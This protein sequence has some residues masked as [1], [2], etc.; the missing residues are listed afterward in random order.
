M[1]P[2]GDEHTGSPTLLRRRLAAELRRLRAA[3]GLGIDEVAEHLCC[4]TSKVSRLET[5]R[6]AAVQRDVRDL[7]DLY[8]V[9]GERREALLALARRARRREDWW[10]HY[11]DVPDVRTY[12]SLEKAANSIRVVQPTTIPGLLQVEEYARLT[13]RHTLPDLPVERIEQLVAA[14]LERGALL[15]SPDPP[16]LEV[17]LDEAAL[18]RINGNRDLLRAQLRRL[19]EAAG[20]PNVVLRVL[21]FSA[22]PHGGLAESFRILSFPDPDDPDLVHLEHPTGDLYLDDARKVAR[23][24]KLFELAQALALTPPRSTAFLVELHRDA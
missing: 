23:Y 2:A 22:G 5:A 10:P 4:S 3:S 15:E 11:R 16:A 6:V 13:L 8:G 14:R 20:M 7:L 17:V 12:I 21:P 18:R 24:R 9:G 19:I 1:P